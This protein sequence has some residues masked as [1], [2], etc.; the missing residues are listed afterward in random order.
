MLSCSSLPYN[1]YLHVLSYRSSLV[2]PGVSLPVVFHRFVLSPQICQNTSCVAGQRQGCEAFR[3]TATNCFCVRSSGFLP[4]GLEWRTTRCNPAPQHTMFMA[5]NVCF[6]DVLKKNKS[7]LTTSLNT[8]ELGERL[9]IGPAG[10][11]CASQAPQLCLAAAR[12]FLRLAPPRRNTRTMCDLFGAHLLMNPLF[13]SSLIRIRTVLFHLPG[14][15]LVL[16]S[17]ECSP[18]LS[19]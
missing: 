12:M 2:L 11:V 10:C 15:L 19:P 8:E 7:S 9:T 5:S 1:P 4:T 14:H 18:S 13:V 16:F 17:V 3:M 6:S